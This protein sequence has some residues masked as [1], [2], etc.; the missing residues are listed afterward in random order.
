MPIGPLNKLSGRQQVALVVLLAIAAGVLAAPQVY[1]FVA[2]DGD[3][4]VVIEMQGPIET[5]MAQDVED[6]L[7]EARQD[8]AVEAVVL[9]VES[10][11][12]LP[13]QSERIYAAVDRTS[14]EMPVIAT[15]DTM[16]AS[17]AYLSMAPADEIYVAPSAQ[18]VGSVGVAGTAPNPSGPNA[19][20]TG[21]DKRGPSTEQQREQ[22]QILANLFVE[23][24]IEQRGDEIDLD[25]EEIAHANSY[26]GTEA[27]N[28]GYA[29][30]FGFVDDAIEDAADEAGLRTYS[31]ETH[32]ADGVGVGMPLIEDDGDI[33]VTENDETLNDAFILAVA[34]EVWEETVGTE[35]KPVSYTGPEPSEVDADAD[36]GVDA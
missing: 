24:V 13:A 6:Q 11:G 30:D 26:L 18:A 5:N 15:V 25:R 27:V 4:V 23:S 14:E 7:R 3:T 21:P 19:G 10:G 1:S 17:G 32:R 36:G 33:V 28:N 12:G 8:D 20:T 16:G 2:D 9:E 22:Q 35:L 29:D 31:V 34:P